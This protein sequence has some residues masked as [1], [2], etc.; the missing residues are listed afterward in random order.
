MGNARA[1]P[2]Y[3]MVPRSKLWDRGI[4]TKYRD[5]KSCKV[6]RG[7]FGIIGIIGRSAL[8]FE[9]RSKY[10]V[11]DERELVWTGV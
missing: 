8:L 3:T 11:V 5:P 6:S 7:Y 10:S 4:I 1:S 2:H 9:V